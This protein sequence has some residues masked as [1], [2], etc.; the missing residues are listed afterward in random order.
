MVVGVKDLP[1]AATWGRL[2]S[3]MAV[4]ELGSIRAAAE[5]LHVTPPAVSAAVAALEAGL[6]TTLF[7]KAGR[8]IVPTDAGD[9]FAGYVRKLL[10]LLTEAAG[11]VHDADR[12]RVR[13]GAVTTASEYVLPPLIASFAVTH[14]HV[15]LSLTVLPRDELFA[16]AADHAIDVVLAGRPPGGSGL[17]TRARRAN[18]LLAVGSPG[19][20][21]DPLTSTW[22]LTAVG[23]G[24]RDTALSLLTR[25]QA[26]PPL[27]TLGT[28]GAVIAA[29]REGIGVTLVHEAAAAEQLASGQLSAYPL[30]GTPLNRPWHLCTT[31][32]P[33][34]ASRL[35]LGHVCDPDV[36]GKAAF[37]TTLREAARPGASSPGQEPTRSGATPR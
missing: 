21:G 4:H 13:I 1:S 36:V 25:L 24:T 37:R 12:G 7:T 30:S 31:A 19:L 20:Q 5:A 17:R 10:G 16:L 14:P 29:A 28:T 35:F 18:R 8:G 6:G 9:T 3:F 27:L 11:A 33:T 22:L 23:S 2:Q 26:A 34:A 32:E 15:E